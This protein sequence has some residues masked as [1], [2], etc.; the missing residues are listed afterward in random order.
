[1]MMHYAQKWEGFVCSPSLNY[2]KMEAV[3]F[4]LGKAKWL[5]NRWDLKKPF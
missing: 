5:G 4:V 2:F 1:M 3:V